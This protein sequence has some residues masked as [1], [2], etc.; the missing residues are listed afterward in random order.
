ML[1]SHGNETRKAI[2]IIM[3]ANQVLKG[4]R[5]LIRENA[6]NSRLTE[7]NNCILLFFSIWLMG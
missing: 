5:P 2:K 1:I 7:N 6:A 3:H 4:L